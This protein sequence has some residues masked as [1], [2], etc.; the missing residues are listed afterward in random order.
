MGDH[1]A[2]TTSHCCNPEHVSKNIPVMMMLIMVRRSAS[3]LQGTMN[4]TMEFNCYKDND[5]AAARRVLI[6]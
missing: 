2:W 6:L 1:A 5:V 4:K 3:D